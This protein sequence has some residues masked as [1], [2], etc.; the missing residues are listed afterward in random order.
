V[1]QEKFMQQSHIIRTVSPSISTNAVRGLVGLALT[2]ALAMTAATAQVASGTTGIDN[3]G[4][5]RSERAACNSGRTQQ[6]RKTCLT[7][8]NNAN[9]AR[10]AGKL[11][12][13][14][15]QFRANALA[16][17]NVLRNED[18]LACEARVVGYGNPQGSVAGG[19]ILTQVETVVVP[20][21][22]NVIVQPKTQ[23][24]T[25]LILPATQ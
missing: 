24:D 18:K 12:N 11:D 25:L 21:A 22:S 15:G 3:T 8:V 14:G 17:C 1:L 6:D 23:N 9:E 16:R 4:N 2:A 19:G 13:S 20:P 10:R 5:A 7:E